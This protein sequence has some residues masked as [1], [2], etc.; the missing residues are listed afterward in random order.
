M[1]V[2]VAM[3]GGTAVAAADP[4]ATPAPTVTVDAIAE[5][6]ARSSISVQTSV[7]GARVG[8]VNEGE[9][10]PGLSIVK[11]YMVDFA[12]RHGDGSESDKSLA[13]RMIRFS[14]DGAASALDAKYPDSIG[15]VAAE[16]GLPATRGGY[17]GFAMTSAA[18]VTTFLRIKQTTDPGSPLFGWMATAGDTAADGTPQNWGTANVRGVLGTKWGW[19]DDGLSGVASVSYGPGFVV[20]MFTFGTT[21]D[22]DADLS[23]AVP[24][25]LLDKVAGTRR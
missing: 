19:G 20:A 18:D 9:S 11:L 3:S 15:A 1:A 16:Y 23:A 10:R 7:P 24:G 8:T 2:A 22:Q 14:D 4:V 6:P 17:W 13:E 5:I 25:L 21:A 12:L